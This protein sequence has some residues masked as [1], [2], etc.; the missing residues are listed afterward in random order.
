MLR[1]GCPK[2]EKHS[3]SKGE[4]IMCLAKVLLEKDREETVYA[5]NISDIRID[6]DM[7]ILTDILGEEYRLSGALV[8]AD[9]VHGEV[10]VRA[11]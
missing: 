7:I 6:G 11:G 3:A 2:R 8:S 5:G 4:I 9:L 1:S 10:R